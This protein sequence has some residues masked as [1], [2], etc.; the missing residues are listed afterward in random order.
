MKD[1]ILYIIYPIVV[2]I[3]MIFINKKIE[4]M[5]KLKKEFF[6]KFCE[7][8]LKIFRS[9]AYHFTDLKVEDQNEFIN[10]IIVNEKYAKGILLELFR[11]FIMSISAPTEN[12]TEIN[13]IFNEITDFVF[14]KIW[15]RENKISILESY[16]YNKK[17]KSRT[18]EDK[19]I[20]YIESVRKNDIIPFS[21]NVD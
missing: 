12:D 10:L 16:Q 6:L 9:N 1:I 15:K 20:F 19:E 14:D 4:K 13:R 21:V 8:H 11:H 2:S 18:A 7:L 17:L 5:G 3:L